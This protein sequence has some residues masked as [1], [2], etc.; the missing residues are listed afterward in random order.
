MN[1]PRS[2]AGWTHLSR[3]ASA[4][5]E[6]PAFHNTMLYIYTPESR[7]L[8]P[9]ASL[10]NRGW[11]HLFE[12]TESEVALLQRELRVPDSLLRHA[13]DIDE[14][15]RIDHDSHGSLL[16][17]TRV[18]W[19][20]ADGDG[21]PYRTAAFSVILHG[22]LAVSIALGTDD[23]AH[24]FAAR[25]EAELGGPVPFL[26][27]LLPRVGKLYIRHLKDIEVAVNQLEEDLKES[28]ENSE[29]L[30][31]LR[32]QKGLVH[33]FQSLTAVQIMLERLQKLP[34]LVTS[35]EDRELLEDALLD[36]RQATEMTKVSSDILSQ[37][38]DAFASIISNNLNIVMRVLTSLT[39]VL[40]IP[41]MVASF[42]G[43]NMSVP[44]QTH[45]WAFWLVVLGSFA[46]SGTVAYLFARRRWL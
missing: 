26:L 24:S 10:P 32:Y 5:G 19:H 3:A 14:L 45:P 20:I 36:I 46:L 31:L 28:Q 11:V 40:A 43:M 27:R 1:G 17:V 29:V 6:P 41:S 35:E 8:A 7:S 22:E 13:T 21:L 33:F 16:V 38:M 15:A 23:L 9:T 2:R 39:I 18:P 12:P 42:Y 44:G 25:G 30:G 34:G 37:M 4:L